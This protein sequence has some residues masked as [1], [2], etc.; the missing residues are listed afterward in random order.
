MLDRNFW[1]PPPQKK[2]L[3]DNGGELD[4]TEFETLCENFNIKIYTS[5]A[6]SPWSNGLIERHN[7]ILDL[8][9]TKTI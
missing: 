2:N 1:P 4:N 9:V 7:A 5:A 8:T 3:V 6:E